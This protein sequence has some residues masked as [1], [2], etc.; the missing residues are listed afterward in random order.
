MGGDGPGH[1]PRAPTAGPGRAGERPPRRSQAP[2]IGVSDAAERR[3]R[4][5]LFRDA[6]LLLQRALEGDPIIGPPAFAGLELR[7]PAPQI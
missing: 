7:H 4:P 3:R 2:R 6:A 1:A 5:R